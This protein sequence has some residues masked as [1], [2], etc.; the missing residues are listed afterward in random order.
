[1]DVF[2]GSDFDP[3]QEDDGFRYRDDE[4]EADY[5]EEVDYDDA[6]YEEEPRH[7]SDGEADEECYLDDNIREIETTRRGMGLTSLSND[8]SYVA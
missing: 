6:E 2:A 8:W 1:M 5:D 7:K 4:E 3:D